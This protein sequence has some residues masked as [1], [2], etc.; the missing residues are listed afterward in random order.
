MCYYCRERPYDDLPDEAEEA[1]R[2]SRRREESPDAARCVEAA[3]AAAG[4]STFHKDTG[5]ALKAF[6]SVHDALL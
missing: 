5:T 6:G 4:R 3:E 1:R 2:K